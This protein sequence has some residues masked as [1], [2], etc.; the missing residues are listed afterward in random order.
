[1]LPT[2]AP[3]A[4]PTLAGGP[5]LCW[6]QSLSLLLK[7]SFDYCISVCS[8]KT[9]AATRLAVLAHT[10]GQKNIG[11][12]VSTATRG[13]RKRCY[14]WRRTSSNNTTTPRN[15]KFQKGCIVCHVCLCV[16]SLRWHTAWFRNIL[17]VRCS[18]FSPKSGLSLPLPTHK[19]TLS[20][21]LSLSQLSALGNSYEDK[22]Q[23]RLNQVRSEIAEKGYYDHTY[24]EIVFGARMAWRN[25]PRCVNRIVWRQLEVHTCTC[26]IYCVVEK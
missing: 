17:T 13:P 9:L 3:L 24:E 22:Y 4:D 11:Q 12:S 18:T 15:S 7:P 21:S 25:A 20:L 6:S 2:L 19:L 5:P 23:T 26:I 14:L 16:P 1:M 10:C 8:T